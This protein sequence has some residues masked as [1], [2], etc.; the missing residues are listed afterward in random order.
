MDELLG[1][2]YIVAEHYRDD[3]RLMAIAIKE[4]FKVETPHNKIYRD[5]L[6]CRYRKWI[7]ILEQSIC[8]L[9]D[10]WIEARLWAIDNGH[11]NLWLRGDFEAIEDYCSR[12]KFDTECE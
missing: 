11:D 5:L 3:E 6:N 10:E 9:S 12:I 4:F 2:F 8:R 7:L 1:R